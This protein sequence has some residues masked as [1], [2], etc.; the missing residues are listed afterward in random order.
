L[1]LRPTGNQLPVPPVA[2]LITM[3]KHRKEVIAM[4]DNVVIFG[5]AG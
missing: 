3:N 2:A 1:G 5:K 4:D